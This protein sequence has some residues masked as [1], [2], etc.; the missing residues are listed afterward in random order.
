MISHCNII[1]ILHLFFAK[2]HMQYK[3]RMAVKFKYGE[4]LFMFALL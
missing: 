1:L 2:I 3:E 4:M